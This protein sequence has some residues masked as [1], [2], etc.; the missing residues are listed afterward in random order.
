MK[1]KTRN[2]GVCALIAVVLLA[3]AVLVTGCPTE[4]STETGYK[5]SAG[6]GA[7]QLKFGPIARATTLPDAADETWFAT[8]GLE[9]LP[10][11]A[12][13][14][15][16]GSPI[17]EEFYT[18]TDLEDPIELEEGDYTL[19]VIGYASIN[20][21]VGVGPAATATLNFSVEIGNTQPETIIL[22]A[23]D[24]DVSGGTGIFAWEITDETEEDSLESIIMNV[25]KIDGTPTMIEDYV[26]LSDTVDKLV[27]ATGESLPV[28]YYY[29][30]FALTTE[31]GIEKEFRHVLHIYRNMISTF[32]YTYND[33]KLGI[34]KVI[35]TEDFSLDIEYEEIEDF[36][37]TWSVSGGS[38]AGTEGDPL[39]LSSTVTSRIITVT[40][41]TDYD[42]LEFYCDGV[43]LEDG[44]G[45]DDDEEL[46]ISTATAPF[47]AAG[48]YQLIIVGIVGTKAYEAEIFIEVQ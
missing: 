4:P 16:P 14:N 29:V 48:V 21:G 23:Y 32:T 46:T 5:P 43:N 8:F 20:A 7:V 15:D 36:A 47:N 24:P 11:N 22:K 6:K 18:L 34:V 1:A 42:S 45:G 44:I 17:A 30:M 40:N 37:P 39:I 3:M 38:E 33:A 12:G 25:I 19:V 28:G 9:F 31:G 27:N 10:W 2:Y 13:P 35:E 26:I 41:F